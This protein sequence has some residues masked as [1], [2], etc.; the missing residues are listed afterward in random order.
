MSTVRPGLGRPLAEGD[1]PAPTYAAELGQSPGPPEAPPATSLGACVRRMAGNSR[2]ISTFARIN[3]MSGPYARDW[4]TI[5]GPPER[6]HLSRAVILAANYFEGEEVQRRTFAAYAIA[7]W[8][9]SGELEMWKRPDFILRPGAFP[10]TNKQ[11]VRSVPGDWQSWLSIEQDELA[12]VLDSCECLVE[13]DLVGGIPGVKAPAYA[14]KAMLVALLE[15]DHTQSGEPGAVIAGASE[16]G[17]SWRYRPGEAMNRYVSRPDV[18]AEAARRAGD[19]ASEAAICRMLV[20]MAGADGA[21]LNLASVK[22]TRRK[23]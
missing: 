7:R 10:T 8:A 21:T 14:D 5:P 11:F 3:F 20:E 1:K 13:P 19:G 12:D 17:A 18:V 6:I 23:L 16:S 22:S 15:R 9:A 2:P 4:P